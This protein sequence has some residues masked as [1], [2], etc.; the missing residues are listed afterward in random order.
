MKTIINLTIIFIGVI[1]S[2][3]MMIII[4]AYQQALQTLDEIK[5]K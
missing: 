1:L 2:Y 5:E 3:P 4:V